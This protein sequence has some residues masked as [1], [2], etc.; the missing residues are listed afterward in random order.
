MINRVVDEFENDL[1]FV[2]IDI[3][4]DTK[5]AEAAGVTGTPVVHVFKDKARVEEMKGVRMKSEYR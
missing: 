1:K 5:I 2:E 3:A 4:A